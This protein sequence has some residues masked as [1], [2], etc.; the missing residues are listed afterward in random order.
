[1]MASCLAMGCRSEQQRAVDQLLVAERDSV[2]Q[3]ARLDLPT[4]RSSRC[5][6][7]ASAVR[8]RVAGGRLTIDA[9]AWYLEQA[10]ARLREKRAIVVPQ[11]G[12]AGL[13]G[14]VDLRSHDLG[15]QATRDFFEKLT[16]L[17]LRAEGSERGGR[18]VAV[19]VLAEGNAAFR[20]VI[21][22]FGMLRQTTGASLSYGLVGAGRVCAL[23]LGWP[24]ECTGVMIGLLG[25]RDRRPLK[26]VRPVVDMNAGRG[27]VR[28][29]GL[30]EDGACLFAQEHEA[31]PG[32]IESSDDGPAIAEA[33]AKLSAGRVLCGSA[34]VGAGRDQSWATV[35]AAIDALLTYPDP[36]RPAITAVSI[37]SR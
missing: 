14:E 13:V 7:A 5:R 30:I 23:D 22:A 34:T 21:W 16:S 6:P 18:P 28:L 11:N 37:H 24:R 3:V 27:L 9:K 29:D 17:G 10:L 2:L 8:A 36:G 31:L 1:M 32:A 25:R 26:C 19:T 12:A 15:W 4:T 33:I 20:D 35:V